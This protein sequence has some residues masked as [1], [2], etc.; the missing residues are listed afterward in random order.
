MDPRTECAMQYPGAAAGI[1]LDNLSNYTVAHYNSINLM[2][3][4]LF[5]KLRDFDY[6]VFVLNW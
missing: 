1:C 5:P 3:K 2:L 6:T 4:N